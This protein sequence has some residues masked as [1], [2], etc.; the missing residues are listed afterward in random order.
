MN[1]ELPV[2]TARA[3]W[4]LARLRLQRLLNL[5]TVSMRRKPAAG[6]AMG[7]TA[8]AGK[9]RGRW[10]LPLV[11]ALLMVLAFALQSQTILTNLHCE[12]TP[13]SACGSQA[14]PEDLRR[15][16]SA[17]L[18]EAPFSA[19][20]QRA[21]AME[22][23]LLWLVALLVPLGSRELAQPDWDLEWLVTLPV[24]RKGL[25]WARVLERTVTNPTGWL[26]LWPTML[27]IGWHAGLRWSAPLAA[28]AAA[29]ALLAL[30]AMVR[31]LV[32]TGL[33]LTLPPSQLR[34]LQAAISVVSLP[35]IYLVIALSTGRGGITMDWARAWPGWTL[36]TPP[37][38]AVQLLDA[39]SLPA[40]LGHAALLAL[41]AG[42]LLWAGIA[43]LARQLSAGVVAASSREAARAQRPPPASLRAL[44]GTALQRR[45][46]RLLGRDR[47]FL[48]QS[49]VVPLVIIGSQLFFTGRMEAMAQLGTDQALL[50]SI[51]FGLGSY[52]LLLSAFQ[53]INTEGQ[54]LWMLYTFPGTLERMLL[55]KAR[56]WAVLALVY[57][58]AVFAI[59]IGYAPGIDAGLVTRMALVALGIPVFAL[60]AVALGVWASD[61][62]AQEAT[63]RIR[64]TYVYLYS[65]LAGLY[66]FA[67]YTTTLP[68]RVAVVVLL[69]ALALA[70]WQKA[71]DHLP[72]LLD[73]AAAPPPR[74]SA[75]D[76]MVAALLFLAVQAIAL[77]VIHRTAG[78]PALPDLALAL[79]IGGAVVWALVR[80]VYWRMGTTGV[81]RFRHGPVLPALLAGAAWA[82]PAI[83]AAALYLVAARH[84][85]IPLPRP[86][87]AIA[88]PLLLAIAC[89]AAPL[90]EEFIFRGL[91]FGGLRRS[92]PFAAATI[93]SAALFAVVHPPP[94][95]LPVFVLGLCTALAYGRNGS[96]L[97]A[98]ATHAVYNGAI[99][100]I[101]A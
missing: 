12:L 62:L 73:P 44:P 47:T 45:E 66:G 38:L 79:A 42:L 85:G 60:I 89:V 26:V 4:L 30:A 34:N 53:T 91:L 78:P 72:Y 84:F 18:R 2:G 19:P 46:L 75:A 13:H 14:T 25:L 68:H 69:V 63:A 95:M 90:S 9:R 56:L 70:L 94:S 81:P 71:R 99:I 35:L 15:A 101:Q 5:A 43:L 8:T 83:A 10:I 20:L 31:T 16:V 33:R 52:V 23:W 92:L 67:L 32:D 28:T 96:L 39:R 76:G 100:A 3:A 40:A 87:G 51:A 36:W 74:V 55:Q 49:L 29:V 57:P 22:L 48:V 77:A 41:Q 27:M 61:P 11:L 21:L 7:R 98:V 37:G 93:V 59:G 86:E 50:A 58:A 97:A 64:P 65:L 1:G 82:I 80:F 54:A 17:Q 88:L 24:R 6:T